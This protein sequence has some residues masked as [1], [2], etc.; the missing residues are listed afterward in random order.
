[1]AGGPSFC[2]LSDL[3]PE[4]QLQAAARLNRPCDFLLLADEGRS[5]PPPELLRAARSRQL[6]VSGSARL[7]RDLPAGNLRRTSQEGS[8]SVPLR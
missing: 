5:A 1:M 6:L 3:D 8:I 2:D 7:S 4:A